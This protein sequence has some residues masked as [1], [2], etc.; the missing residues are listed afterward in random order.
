[1]DAVT[2][3]LELGSN[4]GKR[5]QHLRRGLD[6]LAQSLELQKTSSIYETEPWGY[7][8][9]PLFLNLVCQAS[10]N[11]APEDL[12]VLCQRVEQVAGRNPTFKYGPRVLDVDILAYGNRIINS[13]GLVVPHPRLAE[14]AFV[15]VPMAEIAPEWTH[16]LL[17]Q[18]ASELLN[19]VSGTNGV[20]LWVPPLEVP[21]PRQAG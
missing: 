6:L 10:T 16:P 7:L 21:T 17:Q 4:L 15:L 8:H 18:T 12:L 2:V 11:L 3:F 14:R 1:M 5:E 20:R 19:S 9:Q 13:P